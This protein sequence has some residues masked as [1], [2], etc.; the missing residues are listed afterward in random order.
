[1]ARMRDRNLEIWIADS[2]GGLLRTSR[3]IPIVLG[4]CEK[5]FKAEMP[6]IIPSQ[7]RAHGLLSQFKNK[8]KRAYHKCIYSV[9]KVY[10]GVYKVYIELLKPYFAKKKKS[11]PKLWQILVPEKEITNFVRCMNIEIASFKVAF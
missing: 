1:M 3:P 5:L 7:E 2:S 10:R 4:N 8:L 11:L 6:K 9:N